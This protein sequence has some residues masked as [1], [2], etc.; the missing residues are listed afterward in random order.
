LPLAFAALVLGSAACE[1]K[2]G[3]RKGS[4]RRHPDPRPGV[5]ASAVVSA[6]ALGDDREAI[7]VFSLV[8]EIPQVCDSIRCHCNCAAK[9]G[10]RSLLA[11]FEGEG[12]ARDCDLCMREAERV[13][14]LHRAGKSLDEIRALVDAAYL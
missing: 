11:C 13:Y 1:R 10:V 12:M 6:A 4:E 9:F 3:P 14:R 7:R 5:D 2:A 8:R